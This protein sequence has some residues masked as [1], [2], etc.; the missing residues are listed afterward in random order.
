MFD[1]YDPRGFTQFKNVTKRLITYL[2]EMCAI[3]TNR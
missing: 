2:A 3:H 1:H